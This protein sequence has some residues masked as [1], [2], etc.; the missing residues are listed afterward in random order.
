MLTSEALHTSE[1]S[2]AAFTSTDL[3]SEVFD[4]YQ[5][6]LS[7]TVIASRGLLEESR[8]QIGSLVVLGS[9]FLTTHSF[10]LTD[11]REFTSFG[12]GSRFCLDRLGFTDWDIFSDLS[13]RRLYRGHL[14]SYLYGRFLYRGSFLHHRGR[15]SNRTS[16]DQFTQGLSRAGQC[17]G[18]QCY[19]ITQ[20]E[21][22]GG[23]LQT[24]SRLQLAGSHGL[25]CFGP[26][27]GFITYDTDGVVSTFDLLIRSVDGVELRHTTVSEGT[28]LVYLTSSCFFVAVHQS[29]THSVT[30][31]RQTFEAITTRLDVGAYT[32]QTLEF[33]ECNLCFT[34]ATQGCTLLSGQGV[35]GVSYQSI[36]LLQAQG[37]RVDHGQGDQTLGGF[38]LDSSFLNQSLYLGSLRSGFHL[39]TLDGVT[40]SG[41]YLLSIL[42]FL[43]LSLTL[44][45]SDVADLLTY[46]T[47][48]G[49]FFVQ[50]GNGSF[51]STLLG[52]L[53]L[54]DGLLY[55]G[56]T[57]FTEQ[58]LFLL[59]LGYTLGSFL[60]DGVSLLQ[61]TVLD[62]LGH[63]I[64]HDLFLENYHCTSR[65]IGLRGHIGQ[66]RDVAGFTGSIHSFTRSQSS[67][68]TGSTR[69]G[70][71]SST[72]TDVHG[73]AD[74]ST[75]GCS[76]DDLFQAGVFQ[77]SN[78][79]TP[80]LVTLGH[81]FTSA[82][83]KSRADQT[84]TFTTDTTQDASIG[85]LLSYRQ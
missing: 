38:W 5:R 16:L 35:A 26:V 53:T 18:F 13:D 50:T 81:A 27:A 8:N 79:L 58:D 64:S 77:V 49:Q 12:L 43:G 69:A 63:T 41:Q 39:E 28:Q 24:T 21:R 1:F 9:N 66:G 70:T 71:Y 76:F 52:L 25:R 10:T 72:A 82:G 57:F 36:Y 47:Q 78:V 46:A 51:I 67:L 68:S 7:V 20:L 11:S 65:V 61:G 42:Q 80:G 40:S 54:F 31:L 73:S 55:L 74:S 48:V 60:L 2:H 17:S 85:Y 6:L 75:N 4:C 30:V 59:Q 23:D 44:L 15:T 56:Q 62:L 34:E 84:T 3:G 22:A 83:T 14:F 29:H 19:S 32:A 45:R 33:V 37:I